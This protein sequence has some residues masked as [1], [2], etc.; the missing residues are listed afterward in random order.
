MNKKK[1]FNDGWEFTKQPLDTTFDEVL[2]K[3]SSFKPVELPHDWLIEN[4]YDLYEDS[5]GWYRKRLDLVKEKETL[6]K[7]RFDGVYMDSTLYVN[8]HKVGEWKY[9]YSAFEM[10]LTYYLQDGANEIYMSV[11][12][13]SPN[14]RWYTGA[15]IYR[16]VWFKTVKETHLV[17]NGIYITATP[18]GEDFWKVEID[19]EV[20]AKKRAQIQYYLR[21]HDTGKRVPLMDLQGHLLEPVELVSADQSMQKKYTTVYVKSPNLWQIESP[22]LYELETRLLVEGKLVQIEQTIFGFRTLSYQPDKGFFLNGKHTKLKGVCEHHDLGC[23]GAAYYQAAMK[24]KFITLKKMGVNAVRTAHN[25]PAEEL[26]TLADEMGMLILSESFD[27]WEKPKNK[28]DY[29]RFFLEWYPKDVA[30]WIRRDYNHPSV[31]MWSIGNEIY[32]THE[33]SRGQELAKM[34]IEEVK[35]HDPK[36]HAPITIGSNYMPWENAQKCADLVKLVGYNY[37]EKYYEAHH[38]C[39]PDWIIYGSETASTVQSRGIYHFPFSQSVLAD[40]DEQCSS[41]GNSTT[42]WGAKSSEDC[43]IHERNCNFSC[44]QFI[45]SGHDYIGEPTPYHTKNAYLGQIDTAGFPKDAYYIY[46]AEWTDYKEA[47]MVHI[48]PYWDFNMGQL[49]DI[50]VCSN[51]PR[52]ELFFN[53]ESQGS[54]EIDH[55]HGKQLLGHWKLPYVPGK[56]EAV[57]YDEKG[58]EI[59]RDYKKSFKEPTQIILKPDKKQILSDGKDLVF[60]EISMIDEEGNPVENANNRVKVMVS[61]SGKLMG[62]DNGD[63]TDWE[64]Y[65]G[66]SKRLFSG[67]LL[68]VIKADK[69]QREIGEIQVRVTSFGLPDATFKLKVLPESTWEDTVV[70]E[71]RDLHETAYKVLEEIIDVPVRKIEIIS[72]EGNQLNLTKKEIKVQAKVLPEHATDKKLTWQL[73]DDAGIS[74]HLATLEAEGEQAIIRAIGDGKVRVRCLSKSGTDHICLISQLDINISGLGEAYLDPYRFISGGVYTYSKGTV[75]NGNEKGIA[76]ARDEETQVGFE[77]IDFGPY[78]SDEITIPIFALSDDPY[79]IQIWEGI[80]GVEGS[81]LVAEVIYQK[82]SIWNVYQEATYKLKRPI[83]GISSICFVLQQKIHMKGFFFKKFNRAYEMLHAKENDHIYGD[84]FKVTEEGIREIGNNVT[85]IFENMDFGEEGTNRLVICGESPIDKNSIHVKF[86]GESGE[87]TQ[88]IEFLYSEGEEVR[89]YALDGIKGMQQVS[90]VF[91]PGSYFHFHWF[92]F[93]K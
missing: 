70:E 65:K 83:R 41:L 27:M 86:K 45:W 18:E 56:L 42:S 28:Y 59:A 72:P 81:E 80:P 63:S 5:T 47:P 66:I 29:A 82:P 48:F 92:Q 78:G 90:F 79:P 53:G 77:R 46:Q 74:T 26:M 9:G 93:E 34:L 37:A 23:L 40:D 1:L 58:L 11:R 64:S 7:I 76:T 71:N 24:R 68:A 69:N 57:A 30:S 25:M 35:K 14:S 31:I 43:I 84:F 67:K 75:G 60:V 8:R 51:A 22:K 4:T 89:S 36:G 39:H 61:G 85:V 2:E 52:I 20:V 12:Y 55:Q 15:G 10:D 19:T 3:D 87:E 49:I 88:L 17:S 44:G 6:Y 32:D 54:Y 16:N 91:L 73:V 13:Q 50:R 38:K 62:L 21:H 33:G